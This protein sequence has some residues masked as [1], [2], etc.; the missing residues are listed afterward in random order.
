MDVRILSRRQVLAIPREDLPLVVLSDNLRGLLGWGIKRHTQGSYNHA[1]WF[2]WPGQVASQGLFYRNVP[3][4]KYLRGQHRLKFW[5][6]PSWD[7]FDVRAIR[8]AIR[9]RLSDPWYRRLYD[10]RGIVGHCVGLRWIQSPWRYYCSED[11]ARVLSLIE[12]EFSQ[13][14]PSPAEVNRWCKSMSQMRVYGV[15]DPDLE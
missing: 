10:F 7:W 5:H 6:N 15:F 14:W 3:L 2:W 8:N 13:R 4:E 1:M 12:P 11:V 9:F